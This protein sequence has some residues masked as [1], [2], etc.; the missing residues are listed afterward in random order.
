MQGEHYHGATPQ[1]LSS[2]PPSL[3]SLPLPSSSFLSFFHYFPWRKKMEK[4]LFLSKGER[5]RRGGRTGRALC[6][7]GITLLVWTGVLWEGGETHRK[8]GQHI[9]SGSH[10]DA[11]HVLE[12]VGEQVT[13]W[14]GCHFPRTS[15]RAGLTLHPQPL[16][17][18]RLT[19]VVWATPIPQ[20]RVRSWQ[21]LTQNAVPHLGAWQP[22]APWKGTGTC[23]QSGSSGPGYGEGAG[24]E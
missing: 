12:P 9:G 7:P 14:L 17:E 3:L 18:A 1:H 2:L 23:R 5:R 22:A 20:A 6:G 8:L 11:D 4:G 15:A 10:S 21:G 19:A 16:A 24:L 13:L